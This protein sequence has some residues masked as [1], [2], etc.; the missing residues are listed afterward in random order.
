MRARHIGERSPER[1]ELLKADL[2]GVQAGDVLLVDHPG[3]LRRGHGVE[4]KLA[5]A[6]AATP[7]KDKP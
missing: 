6:K 5:Q 3:L 7:A 4:D 2:R 1:V